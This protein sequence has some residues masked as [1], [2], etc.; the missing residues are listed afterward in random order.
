MGL[1]MEILE[2]KPKE[3]IGL[4]KLGME[5]AEVYRLL[6]KAG[7]LNAAVEW[8]GDYHIEYKNNKVVFIEIPNPMVDTTFVL[9]NGVDVFKTEANLLVRF[10]S[11]YGSYDKSEWE[12][13]YSCKFP[14]LGIGLWRPSVFTYEM[15]NETSFKEMD[16]EIQRDEIKYLYFEA[17][18]V[19]ISDYYENASDLS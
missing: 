16:E 13:G 1:V 4:I 9:F 19:Y 14:S 11:D 18:C 17:V 5:R 12:M 10:I 6:N 15:I 7:S 2:I 8:V 3:G